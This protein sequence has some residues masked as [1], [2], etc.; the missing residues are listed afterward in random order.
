MTLKEYMVFSR[1]LGS[2]EWAFLI[3]HHSVREA[4]KMAWKRYGVEIGEYT[5]LA[6]KWLRAPHIFFLGDQ[7]KLSQNIPHTVDSP[8]FC[9][10][11]GWWGEVVINGNECARC[12]E[13]PG[14]RLVAVW[15]D[16]HNTK[17]DEDVK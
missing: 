8:D 7:E 2:H 3:F 14:D 5:D 15:R 12:G 4:K 1:E 11:C 9:E 6:V 13:Y 10:S 16:Y 17:N